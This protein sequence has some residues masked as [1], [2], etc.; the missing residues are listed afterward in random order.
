MDEEDDLVHHGRVNLR[1]W[2]A[3]NRITRWRKP[4]DHRPTFNCPAEDD[5]EQA[6]GGLN[7]PTTRKRSSVDVGE[8]HR[9]AENVNAEEH[10]SRN[11]QR[12]RKDL[13]EGVQGTRRR[14]YLQN[15]GQQVMS[16][17][18]PEGF[19]RKSTWQGADVR[20]PLV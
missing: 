17:R 4:V 12:K 6:S 15:Y 11:I 18:T 20:R 1:G 5:E 13:R 9:R 19:V 14:E 10:G 7:G 16:V 2:P 3:R 8:S